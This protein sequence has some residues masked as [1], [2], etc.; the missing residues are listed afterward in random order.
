MTQDLQST[1]EQAWDH[2]ADLSPSN[3]DTD[4]RTAVQAVMAALDTGELR[5]AEKTG[6]DWVVHQWVNKAV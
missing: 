1:I 2:R 5:V 6:G 3:A 4:I